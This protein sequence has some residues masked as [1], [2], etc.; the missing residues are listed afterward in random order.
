MQHRILSFLLALFLAAALPAAA[1][2]ARAEHSREEVRGAYRAIAAPEEGSPY[3]AE[4]SPRAPYDA[5]ALTDSVRADALAW[6]NFTRWLADVEPVTESRIY[7][8]QCQR[9]AVLLAA[10]D[11]VDHNA[12]NPGD[13]D[14]DFYDSAHLATTSSSIA[15][16]NWLRPGILRDGVSYFLRDDGEANL[17]VLG[18]RR[19][20]LNPMMAATGFGLANSAGGASY[21][22]MY[23]HD[24]GRPDAEWDTVRWPAAGAFPAELMHANLAWSIV[25]NPAKYDLAASE[26]IV[27]LSEERLGLSFRFY[28]RTGG[29]D[30]SCALNVEGYG[31]G[32]CLI[33]RP[34]FDAAFTDYQ[35]NQRW[36]VEVTGLAD[37]EGNDASMAYTVEMISLHAEDV[38]AVELSPQEAVLAPGETLR[39]SAELVPAYADDL[40]V[41]W[42]STDASVAEVDA[43]GQ[44]AALA[45]GTCEII[46]A[47]SNG[48]W[49]ACRLTVAS[50]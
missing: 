19:W 24:L 20:A 2:P 41:A 31:P 43:D 27:T 50:K 29:G 3:A 39:L 12:P 16:L 5:G 15:R 1:L 36:R 28:P 49:D 23:A 34:D 26:P 4:P 46:A 32:P 9:G 14:A 8:Y 22:V 21:V 45:P 6:L 7:D 38:A 47:A 48:R 35:Q 37:A 17:T 11:Y 44:V 40:A 13:M 25:L 33:F 10:L 30:G 42:R 18:H